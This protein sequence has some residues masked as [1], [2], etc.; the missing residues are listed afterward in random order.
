MS[1]DAFLSETLDLVIVEIGEAVLVSSDGAL[2]REENRVAVAVVVDTVDGVL[3]EEK[4]IFAS[5]S[6]KE[7][8]SVLHV[9]LMADNRFK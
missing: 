4:P 2:S 9:P 6:I 1:Y 5:H 3:G 7:L 8:V